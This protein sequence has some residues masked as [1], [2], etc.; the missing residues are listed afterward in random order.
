[1]T[2]SNIANLRVANQQLVDATAKNAADLVAYLGAVQGQEYALTKWGLG[3]RVPGSTDEQIETLLTKGKILRTHL[4]RPTWHFVAAKDIRWM[5]QLTAPRVHAA[6]AYMYR[7]SELDATTFKKCHKLMAAALA[8]KNFL[9]RDELNEIFQQNKIKASGH[10]LSYIM[11]HAELE[12]LIC[13]GPRNGNQFTYALID[14]FVS[15]SK[16]ISGD[17]ALIELTKRY[18]RSRGPAT[19]KDFA[20][21]SGLT[22]ADCKKGIA[23]LGKKLTTATVEKET[24]YFFDDRAPAP[25][26]GLQLLPVYDEMIMGYKNRDAYFGV[27]RTLNGQP[28]FP[29]DS[30]LLWDGQIVGTWK[31]EVKGRAVNF[32]F[33]FFFKPTKAQ[34]LA[35]EESTQ[36]FVEFFDLTI[37]SSKLDW[38][39]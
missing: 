39:K 3:L 11:M 9:T 17:D 23:E 10:R 2:L 38:D 7:Q 6:N 22:A 5:L 18:F 14:E 20:T 15:P 31:R 19:A 25:S 1:M 24:Y 4:L 35:L 21:W 29:F 8:G 12:G 13:S 16:E 34:Q 27:A 36:R 33:Q 32:N 37:G 28:F 26:S 30:M